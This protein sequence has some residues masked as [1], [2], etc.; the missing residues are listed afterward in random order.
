[1]SVMLIVVGGNVRYADV[2]A[3]NDR[4][5]DLDRVDVV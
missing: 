5:E 4:S 1:M 2:W 3:G